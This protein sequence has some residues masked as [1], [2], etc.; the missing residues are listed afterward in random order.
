MPFKSTKTYG[1]EQ[2]L[3]CAFRQWRAN[4]SH[5]HLVHGYALSFKFVFSASALDERGW[6]MDFGGLK[7]L[8]KRLTETFDHV[9]AVAADDPELQTFLDMHNKD[10]ANV[11]VFPEG[12]GVERFAKKAYDMACNVLMQQ[13]YVGMY[14]RVWVESCE[15]AEHGA[16]SAI[17][18]MET[19]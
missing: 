8:K 5:C 3:S 18:S 7:L 1:H 13:G 14:P 9:L 16:N 4:T 19:V 6:V 15:C 11:V 2:G 12:V 17:F 10:M